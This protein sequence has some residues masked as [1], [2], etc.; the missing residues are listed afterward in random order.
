MMSQ[1]QGRIQDF[2]SSYRL[3]WACLGEAHHSS[4]SLTFLSKSDCSASRL[5]LI[6]GM[7][8]LGGAEIYFTGLLIEVRDRIQRAVKT[9]RA[10]VMVD[11][12]QVQRRAHESLSGPKQLH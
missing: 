8:L 4:I 6:F 11:N 10:Q 2:T 9:N 5:W 3:R 7:M 1:K 12:F